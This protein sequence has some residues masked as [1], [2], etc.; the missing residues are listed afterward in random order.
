MPRI[1]DSL[2][3]A[4]GLVLPNRLAKTAMTEGLAEKGRPGLD[5]QTV[6]R[7]WAAS[8]VGLLITGN[9]MIDRDHLERPGNVVIDRMPDADMRARLERWAE[10]AKSSGGKVIMQLS[11]AGRQTPARVNKQ[12]KAPSVVPVNLPGWQFGYPVALT[13]DEIPAIIDRFGVAAVAAREGGFDG[14]QVHAAH[15]Y[16]ISEFLSPKTNRRNDGWGGS[17]ENRARLLLDVVRAVRT[18]AGQEFTLAVK[19]NSSDF[20][21]GGFA[22]EDSLTVAGWLKEVGVDLLEISGG[23]YEQPRMM[24]IEGVEEPFEPKAATTRLREAYFLDFA[25]QMM[26]A[27]VPPLMVTG[28]FRSAD[29]MDEALQS[30][31]DLIGVGRPLCTDP[32]AVLALLRG[33]A[34]TLPRTE[35]TLRLGP[36][37]FGPNSPFRALKALNGFA[38]LAWYYQQIRRMSRGEAPDL[39]LSVLQAFLA[40]QRDDAGKRREERA[41][42]V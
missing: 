7:R 6:Y 41:S 33:A 17:L 14:V 4:S 22:F 28:G 12:P 21:K 36:G 38:T 19:L 18:A 34:R 24:A 1:L 2:T 5:L 23:S 26:K 10:A 29:A 30:G 9:V 20:Q 35:D 42:E 32:D 31:I 13:E 8:G 27:P 40:E 15:G 11:H 3:L 39:R 25:K 37:L 16:L